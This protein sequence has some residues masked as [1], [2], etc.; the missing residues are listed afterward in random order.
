LEQRVGGEGREGRRK[1]ERREEDLSLFF[2]FS[3]PFCDN[4]K[5]S[6]ADYGNNFIHLL[7]D[8]TKQGK[9]FLVRNSHCSEGKYCCLGALM[10]VNGVLAG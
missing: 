1:R 10:R 6:C 7:Q 2:F 5:F 4:S 3:L 9:T 8:K